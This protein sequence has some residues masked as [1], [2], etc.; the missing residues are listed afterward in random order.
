M[1]TEHHRKTPRRIDGSPFPERKLAAFPIASRVAFEKEKMTLE[2][3]GSLIQYSAFVSGIL[4]GKEEQVYIQVINVEFT[5]E[6][7]SCSE[8]CMQRNSIKRSRR[9]YSINEG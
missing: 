2:I 6:T 1:L 5:K 3:L 4:K 9:H 8:G 7:L